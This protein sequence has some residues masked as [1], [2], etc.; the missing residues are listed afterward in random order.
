MKTNYHTHTTRCK[1]AIGRDEEYVISAIKG[2]Y[3]E[4]G[5]SD[6]S[7]WNYKT[8]GFKGSI[9]M[10]KEELMGYLDSIRTLKEK[11]KDYISIKIGLECEYFEE[12]MPWLVDTINRE[13]LDYI[14]FGNHYY[15]SD[16][17]GCY[18]GAVNDDVSLLYTY[19]DETLKGM[20][21]GL[22]SYLAHAD[23]FMRGYKRFDAH[24][25]DIS[26]SICQRAKELN[27]PVEYNLAGA[28]YNKRNGVMNYPHRDFWKVA[29]QV[30]CKAIIG[31]DAH[32]YRDLEDD[33]LREEGIE[34]L[35]S[36][37]LEVVDRISFFNH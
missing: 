20:E 36:L 4:L 34:F 16:E 25:E 22:Y 35:D 1:H 26:I 10:G 18:F 23:L 3:E 31:V 14:I 12:Y 9:R 33:T 27:L 19:R 13:K 30:G 17:K 21:T 15:K 28:A 6:H 7:P 11:Y 2:G 29:S 5:F 32:D 8:P 24:C 37:N